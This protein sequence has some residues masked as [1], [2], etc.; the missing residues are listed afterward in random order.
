M[1][2]FNL[3]FDILNFGLIF[4]LIRKIEYYHSKESLSPFK[5]QDQQQNLEHTHHFYSTQ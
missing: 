1:T 3:N 5:F 2:L 4:K